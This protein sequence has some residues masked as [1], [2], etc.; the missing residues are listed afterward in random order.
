MKSIYVRPET[1]ILPVLIESV[2]G[3]TDSDG[4][5]NKF[6]AKENMEI[7]LD[8]DFGSL[9]DDNSTSVDPWSDEE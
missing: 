7:V 2:M 5:K 6:D 1:E 8:D 9:W 3:N 4:L